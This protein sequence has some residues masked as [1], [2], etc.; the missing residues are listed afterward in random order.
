MNAVFIYVFL[1]KAS[2]YVKSNQKNSTAE[3]NSKVFLIKTNNKIN[4]GKLI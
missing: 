3:S 1:L 4:K 2:T